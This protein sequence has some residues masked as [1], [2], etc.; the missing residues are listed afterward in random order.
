MIANLL[1]ETHNGRVSH[2]ARAITSPRG[3]G[4]AEIVEEKKKREKS[5]KL[6]SCKVLS[7]PSTSLAFTHGRIRKVY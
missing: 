7:A 2:V 1:V 3:V 4:Y 6:N 5:G